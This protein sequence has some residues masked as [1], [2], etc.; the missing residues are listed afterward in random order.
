MINVGPIIIRQSTAHQTSGSASCHHCLESLLLLLR[1][2]LALVSALVLLHDGEE[3][4]CPLGAPGDVQQL[5]PPVR[6]EGGEPVGE[7]LV[8]WEPDPGDA[9]VLHIGHTAVE[10]HRAAWHKKS[11]ERGVWQQGHSDNWPSSVLYKFRDCSCLGLKLVIF[12]FV[13]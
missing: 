6:G 9:R 3:L 10:P 12:A 11:V 4:Q 1:A 13:L 2:H 8:I 7:D 5:E